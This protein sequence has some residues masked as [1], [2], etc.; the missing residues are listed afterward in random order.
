MADVEAFIISSRL[1]PSVLGPVATTRLTPFLS[2]HP[3]PTCLVVFLQYVP[4][5]KESPPLS[6]GHKPRSSVQHINTRPSVNKSTSLVSSFFLR[7]RIHLGING[8]HDPLSGNR[9]TFKS[10]S[11]GTVTSLFR[12][13]D[14]QGLPSRLLSS[15]CVYFGIRNLPSCFELLASVLDSPAFVNNVV[16]HPG[17]SRQMESSQESSSVMRCFMAAFFVVVGDAKHE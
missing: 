13:G 11:P 16:V 8:K 14:H 3:P 10:Y 4:P 12:T 17:K 5:Y 6:S 7:V 2:I 1:L 9:V 15:L